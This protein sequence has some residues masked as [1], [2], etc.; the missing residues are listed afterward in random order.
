VVAAPPYAQRLDEMVSN[1]V[2]TGEELNHPLLQ[3]RPSIKKAEVIVLTSDRGLAG[4]FNANIT[5]RVARFLYE[6]ART[7]ESI[8]L[9]TIGRKGADF[10]R[11]RNVTI[12]KDYAGFFAGLSYAKAKGVADELTDAYLKGEVDAVFIAYNEF[13]SAISQR[14]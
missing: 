5:R 12:R 7:Y 13:V 4:G 10:F 11:R 8:R 14:V 1:L 2:A 9:S 6:N 3:A